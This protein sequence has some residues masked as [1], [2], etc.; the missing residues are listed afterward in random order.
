MVSGECGSMVV[1]VIV[2]L[3]FLLSFGLRY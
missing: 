2:Q 1:V 3:L